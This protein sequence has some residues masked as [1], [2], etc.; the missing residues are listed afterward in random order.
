MFE[1]PGRKLKTF[2]TTIFWIVAGVFSGQW[3]YSYIK[4]LSRYGDY[5]DEMETKYLFEI[6]GLPILSYA[7]VIVS[8]ILITYMLCSI[9]ETASKTAETAYYTRMALEK[10]S[11]FEK[12]PTYAPQTDYAPA[13]EN[14]V[15]YVPETFTPEVPSE[16]E[17]SEPATPAV[18]EAVRPSTEEKPSEA[19]VKF[20]ILCGK[21]VPSTALFCPDCGNKF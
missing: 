3:L 6:L 19:S 1:N 14:P 11:D 10:M 20:C 9:G 15:S 17:K 12:T 21:K 7:A 13:S 5:L 4:M 18:E 16:Q 2:A 8:M